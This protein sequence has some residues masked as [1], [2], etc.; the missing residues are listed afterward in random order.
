MASSLRGPSSYV[1]LETD[2][3]VVDYVPQ[4]GGL[5]VE[6]QTQVL[7]EVESRDEEVAQV[8]HKERK[9]HVA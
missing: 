4:D 8:T 1:P 6:A 3:E 7:I 2:E 5:K 9:N